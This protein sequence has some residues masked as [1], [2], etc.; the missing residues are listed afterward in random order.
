S[1]RCK[2]DIND[3]D[4]A[5]LATFELQQGRRGYG[6]LWQHFVRISIDAVKKDFDSLDV[7]FDLWLVESDSNKFIDEM[8]S[9]FQA[10]NFIY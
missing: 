3:R 4:K 2:S 10:N 7:N 9:Y 5:R 6:A 8:I 1:K